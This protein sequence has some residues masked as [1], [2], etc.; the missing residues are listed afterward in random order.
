MMNRSLVWMMTTLPHSGLTYVVILTLALVKSSTY[1]LIPSDGL[2]TMVLLFGRL[3]MRK[4]ALLGLVLHSSPFIPHPSLITPSLFT[5]FNGVRITEGSMLWGARAL[6][7]PFG[8][9]HFH[10]HSH[11]PRVLPP[12]Q[13]QTVCSL[14]PPLLSDVRSQW[15]PNPQ[16][17]VELYAENPERLLNLHFAFVVLLRSLQ[18]AAPYLS[19]KLLEDKVSRGPRV[20]HKQPRGPIL[21][22]CRIREQ[23]NCFIVCLILILSSHVVLFSVLSMRVCCLRMTLFGTL[24]QG[25]GHVGWPWMDVW[26]H[27]NSN[28]KEFFGT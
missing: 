4:I 15:M 2:D 22:G 24:T 1:S 10:R 17:F 13:R 18:K 19:D 26:F 23:S 8:H 9:A 14:F 7:A 20:I 27:W 28:S 21:I 11:K 16:R 12:S 25:A 3:S 6:Q 5:L